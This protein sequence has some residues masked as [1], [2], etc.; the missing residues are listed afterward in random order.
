M[1]F[2]AIAQPRPELNFDGRILFK[3]LLQEVKAKRTSAIRSTGT[4][5]LQTT[6]MDRKKFNEVIKEGKKSAVNLLRSQKRIRTIA[7]GV[8]GHSVRKNG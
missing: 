4:T 3:P 7:D 5:M 6:Q 1:Y 8:G 2:A